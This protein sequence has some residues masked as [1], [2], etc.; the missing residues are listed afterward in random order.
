MRRGVLVPTRLHDGIWAP[1]FAGGAG[2]GHIWH[3][4]TTRAMVDRGIRYAEPLLARPPVRPRKSTMGAVGAGAELC[5]GRGGGGARRRGR[6]LHDVTAQSQR[7]RAV[8]PTDGDARPTVSGDTAAGRGAAVGGARLADT[9]R[10]PGV[11]EVWR[12]NW[13]ASPLG[14]L[15][16]QTPPLAADLALV[17]S[18]GA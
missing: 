5:G 13:T 14:L 11:S 7:E 8:R 3:W 16:I 15:A 12:K 18:S 2:P 4:S 6:S 1:L 17:A 9:R 10:G